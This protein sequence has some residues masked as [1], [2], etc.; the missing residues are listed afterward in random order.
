MSRINPARLAAVCCPEIPAG[1]D[2]PRLVAALLAGSPRVA[3]TAPGRARVDARGW[4]RL[5]GER[6]LASTL[7]QALKTAGYGRIGI[8]I[9]DVAVAA[10]A[11]AALAATE[12]ESGE[13]RIVP[14]GGAAGFLAP[15]DLDA[16]PLSDEMHE[17]L[18]ALGFRRAGDVA[19]REAAEFEARFG[20]EGIRAHRW[21]SGHDDRVFRAFERE[22][23]PEYGLELETPATTL[24]P[25]LFVLRHLLDRLC[26]DL[27][28]R[29]RCVARLELVLRS[30]EEAEVAS[31]VPARPTSR[32]RLLHELCRA[33]LERAIRSGDMLVRPVDGIILRAARL[34]TPDARQE[35]LFTR[36]WRDPLA[37]ATALSRLR[38][39][40]G[41]AGVVHPVVR[42]D[43]RPESRSAWE[44]VVMQASPATNVRAAG[45]S[46]SWKSS[47]AREAIDPVPGTLHL[48]S[49][50]R[51][52]RVR[53]EAGRPVELSGEIGRMRVE[54]AEGPERLS[55]DWWKRPYH[56]EY[57]RVCT[58]EGELLWIFRDYRAGPD[59]WRLHGWWD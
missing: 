31:A 45:A 19:S 52:L 18:R 55:G 10:D 29:G 38:A 27:T 1:A 47:E 41:E 35:E 23:T 2:L 51:P 46:L 4:E 59:F 58:E 56:R 16:L 20:A 48:L 39:R 7:R 9:A 37:A 57:F 53:L 24:E 26:R 14:V 54:A 12:S 21:A 40:L 5:G 17:T 33:A 34:V 6:V 44:P 28:A 49:V 50:P 15:L 3:I 43:H 11:A 36:R 42:S 30:G 22:D 8:G 13:D 25:L 32:E